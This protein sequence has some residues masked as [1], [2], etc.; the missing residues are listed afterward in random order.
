[1]DLRI[2]GAEPTSD[3]T[4]AV[5]RVLGPPDSGWGGGKRF[6]DLDGHIARAESQIEGLEAERLKAAKAA[7]A[8]PAGVSSP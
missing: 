4:A 1:M 6:V 2:T 3:E 5:D 7:L 8:T